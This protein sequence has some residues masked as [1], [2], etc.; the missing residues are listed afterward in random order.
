MKQ[1]ESVGT[2]CTFWKW[3][4]KQDFEI[5]SSICDNHRELCLSPIRIFSSRLPHL[6]FSSFK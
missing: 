5:V 1:F 2:T 3:N 6:L 4:D